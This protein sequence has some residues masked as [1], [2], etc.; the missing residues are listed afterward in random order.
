M[1]SCHQFISGLGPYLRASDLPPRI[2]QRSA[3]GYDGK[4]TRPLSGFPM[5][6]RRSREPDTDRQSAC[7]PAALSITPMLLPVVPSETGG[8]VISPLQT[9]PHSY[10]VW[11]EHCIIRYIV[12]R[13]RIGAGPR[14]TQAR[15]SG[16]CKMVPFLDLC[17]LCSLCRV[18][19]LSTTRRWIQGRAAGMVRQQAMPR[20]DLQRRGSPLSGLR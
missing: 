6:V 7:V 17:S 5:R 1:C 18:P 3:R 11:L 9:N 16:P 14:F 19:C 4:G 10:Y 8:W 13:A 20:P 12:T 15:G 2:Q